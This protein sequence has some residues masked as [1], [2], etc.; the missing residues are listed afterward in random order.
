M[1]TMMVFEIFGNFHLLYLLEQ[2]LVDG[3][4]MSCM[5]VGV[6]GVPMLGISLR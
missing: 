2:I 3:V 1:T 5:I 6:Q 4:E